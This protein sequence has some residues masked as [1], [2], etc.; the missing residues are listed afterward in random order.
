LGSSFPGEGSGRWV[1]S[2]FGEAACR[3][4]VLDAGRGTGMGRSEP[5]RRGPRWVRPAG[6]RW[7]RSGQGVPTADRIGFVLDSTRGDADRRHHDRRAPASPPTPDGIKTPAPLAGEGWG[8]GAAPPVAS[9][10]RGRPIRMVMPNVP[11]PDPPPQ[12]G[13][14][15]GKRRAGAVRAR[16]EGGSVGR[17]IWGTV[18]DT[19]QTH[20][21]SGRS[22]GAKRSHS[23]GRPG[24]PGDR[25]PVGYETKP[26]VESPE[27]LPDR[28]DLAGDRGWRDGGLRGG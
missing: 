17:M 10:W 13:R 6:G 21:S 23:R 11:H 22:S 7:V 2:G 12:G 4:F 18:A 24:R 20:P 3:G 5:G 28:R 8:G 27:H 19:K 25:S 16:I 26:L 9:S 14:G 15:P 1:R